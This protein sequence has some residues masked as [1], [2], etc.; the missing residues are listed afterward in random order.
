MAVYTI[1]LTNKNQTLQT[2]LLGVTYTITVRWNALASLWYLD[3]N[4]VN[5]NPILN[6]VPMV[7][8][9]DLLK[10]FAYLG[11]GG[12]LVA[13]NVSNPNEP[14]DENGLGVTGFL[15]FIPYSS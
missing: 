10:Q 15:F 11:V 4:D 14:I 9:V 1:P 8:G 7:A 12:S 13:Q 6:G 2:V 5:N 3:I